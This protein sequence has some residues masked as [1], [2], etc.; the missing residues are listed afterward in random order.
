[1]Q[2]AIETSDIFRGAYLLCCGARVVETR[3]VEGQV[4]FVI[5][6]ER[7]AECDEKYRLG[8]AMVN[9]LMLRET[10][11]LLRDLVFKKLRPETEKRR[12]HGPHTHGRHRAAQANG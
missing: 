12:P 4:R 5:E 11:N 3:L 8:T 10:L 9:P 7:V 6:G 2:S 1:M